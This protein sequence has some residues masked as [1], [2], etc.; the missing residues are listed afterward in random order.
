[1]D[2]FGNWIYIILMFVVLISSVFKSFTKKKEQQQAQIPVP[3]EPEEV[4]PVPPVPKIKTKKL[5]PPIPVQKKQ[6][7][8]SLFA[9]PSVAESLQ[10]EL[11]MMQ[12]PE[13]TLADELDLSDPES[14]R[15]AIIYSEI[16][17]RKY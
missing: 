1:M 6:A 12:E 4:F 9:S 3:E 15:K 5:P 17:N 2:E 10:T 8:S 11:S 16:I 7:Y 13:N 14:F